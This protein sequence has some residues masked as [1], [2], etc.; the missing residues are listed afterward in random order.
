MFSARL[1][2]RSSSIPGLPAPAFLSPDF[3]QAFSLLLVVVLLA[4]S[5]YDYFC[6]IFLHP[7][8]MSISP[9]LPA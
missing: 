4:L 6:F 2:A 3:R 7:T 9:R 8:P 5:C 1:L